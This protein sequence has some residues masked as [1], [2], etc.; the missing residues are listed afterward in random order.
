MVLDGT[1]IV[2]LAEEIEAQSSVSNLTLQ[3]DGLGVNL[4]NIAPGLTLRESAIKLLDHLN[5]QV[6]PRTDEF[7][8]LLANGPNARLKTAA[9]ELLTPNFYSP[10][11]DP[12]GAILLGRTAFV[13][14]DDLRS[15]LY[16]F[17]KYSPSTTRVLVI[18]GD[19][20]GGKSYSWQFLRHLAS[21]SGAYAVTLRLK[22]T[23]YTPRELFEQVFLLLGLNRAEIPTLTDD[24]QLTKIDPYINAFK[25][26]LSNLTRRYWLVIDDINEK[27]VTPP[28]LNALYAIAYSVEDL[29]PTNLWIALIGYNLPIADPDLRFIADDY[30][31]FPTADLVGKHL[32]LVAARGPRPLNTVRAQE[33]ANLLFSKFPNPLDKE[34][35]IKLTR[36]VESAGEKL[37]RGLQP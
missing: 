2:R 12:H 3:A 28:V 36:L 13:A 33:I 23:S 18:R 27:T 32:E 24:P 17:T 14:R 9:I 35:M 31:E 21:V 19:K 20:P 7:L 4:P 8:Q 5:S 15:R 10:T 16:E 26:Q 29:K 25:G 1:Q 30:A 37:E 6:P 11:G 22:G 34:A